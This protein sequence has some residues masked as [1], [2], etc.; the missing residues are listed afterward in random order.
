LARY[1][2]PAGQSAT[3]TVERVLKQARAHRY[4]VAA[5]RPWRGSNERVAVYGV[6]YSEHSSF[7]ELTC[8]ALSIDWE[9]MVPTVGA[10]GE[11]G[12][13]EMRVWLDRWA[14]A[15]REMAGAMVEHRCEDYW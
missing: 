14:E 2:P 11:N 3:P 7:R 9:R 8:F 13:E 1:V 4:T 10:S 5:L 6:P 15:R 12:E